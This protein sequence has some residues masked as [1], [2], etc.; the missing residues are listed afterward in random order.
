[1]NPLI[2]GVGGSVLAG[3]EGLQNIQ[4][5]SAGPG[6][7]VVGYTNKSFS[8][9]LQKKKKLH[10]QLKDLRSFNKLMEINVFELSIE[11]FVSWNL[12]GKI[13]IY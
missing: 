4:A 5:L 1:L 12:L 2:V 9:F 7:L 6:R 13:L 8:I 10:F 3:L 11:S